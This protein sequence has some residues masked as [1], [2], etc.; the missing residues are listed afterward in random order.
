MPSELRERTV[1]EIGSRI[2][3][4]LSSQEHSGLYQWKKSGTTRTPSKLCNVG[5]AVLAKAITYSART[6]KFVLL[7]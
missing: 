1:S 2:L 5:G 3:L 6:Q 4:H 7:V